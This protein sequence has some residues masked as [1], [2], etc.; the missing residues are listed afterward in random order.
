MIINMQTQTLI[1][2][3]VSSLTG[4]V[5]GYALRALLARWQSEAMER[6]AEGKLQEADEEAKR[7]L[8]EADIKARAEIVKAREAF[9]ET[10]RERQTAL[11]E[12]DDR[13]A[14]READIER[15][16]HVLDE[17]ERQL[18]EVTETQRATA[19]DFVKRE[20]DIEAKEREAERNLRKIAG[21]TKAEALA[22]LRDSVKEQVNS[23]CGTFYRRRQEE[24]KNEADRRAAEI[25]SYAIKRYCGVHAGEGMTSTVEIPTADIKGRI[26]GRDGRNVRTFEAA[27][28]VTLLMD[29]ATDSVVISCFNPIRR[30]IASRALAALVEDGRLHPASIEVAVKKAKADFE[31]ALCD[32]GN[33]TVKA[34]G[35]EGVSN[36]LTM[37]VGRLKYRSSYSQNLLEHSMEV[38]R[39][40]GSM[41]EELKLDVALARRIGLFH[42]L[43]KTLSDEKEGPHSK[44]G[45]EF[46]EAEGENPIVINAVAAHHD[47]VE[48]K[49]AYAL[50]CSAADAISS[51]RPGARNESS[52]VYYERLGQMESLAKAHRGVESAYAMKAG[53]ELRVAVKADKISE[54]EAIVLAHD[55]SGE[56]ESTLTYPGQIRVVVIREKRFVEYAR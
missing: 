37:A 12:Y 51:A 5:I 55:I 32:V 28:G 31:A 45:A 34:L 27:T 48:P 3:L 22:A 18:E 49:S 56:I 13:I 53:H 15:K 35:L 9:A 29:G 50:L 17:K 24:A 30:E 11:E 21:M 19:A 52:T 23:E 54:D 14:A 40:M 2:I 10:V 16:M 7:R 20:D 1:A 44:I 26:I 6:Q 33:E 46:L 41:A 47:D 4:L 8:R 43:G 25:V 36:T 42:D 38:A 39:L